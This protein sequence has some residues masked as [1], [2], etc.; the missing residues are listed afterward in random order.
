MELRERQAMW[1]GFGDAYALAAEMV[2]TP[3]LFALA[4]WGLDR[5]LDTGPFLAMG[6]GAVGV[7]GVAVRIYYTYKAAMEREEEGKPWTRSRP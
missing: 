6:L 5:W 7:V 3:L 1:K 2:V 4:G